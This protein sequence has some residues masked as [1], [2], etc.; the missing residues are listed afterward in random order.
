MIKED[1]EKMNKPY[2]SVVIPVYNE[3]ENLEQ[4]YQRLISSLDKSGETYEIILVNDGSQDDSYDRLNEL[5][6]DDQNKFELFISMG[7][8]VS[9]W[10]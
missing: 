2:I 4:L 9:I 5:Q 6:K 7:I 1:K 10:L 3:S 8:L